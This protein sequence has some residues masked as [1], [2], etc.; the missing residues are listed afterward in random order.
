MLLEIMLALLSLF[1]YFG[2]SITLALSERWE[3]SWSSTNESMSAAILWIVAVPMLL[4]M[5]AINKWLDRRKPKLFK[6]VPCPTHLLAEM[7]AA[8][9][10]RYPDKL[11]YNAGEWGGS[12]SLRVAR[13]YSGTYTIYHQGKD[14]KVEERASVKVIDKAFE[15]AKKMNVERNKLE[16]R[17]K[18]DTL[19]LDII[20]S[21]T[22][23]EVK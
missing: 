1:A 10:L 19:A 11:A 17:N 3:S 15:T 14:V 8:Q 12:N 13:N 20:E 22:V 21:I 2:V 6:G 7:A 18:R 5:W 9:V 23:G 4:T 16:A